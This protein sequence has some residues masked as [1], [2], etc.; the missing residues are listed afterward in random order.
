MGFFRGS[1]EEG[2]DFKVG[3]FRKNIKKFKGRPVS[4]FLDSDEGNISR[5]EYLYCDHRR[6]KRVYPKQLSGYEPIV[7]IDFDHGHVDPLSSVIVHVDI[8][9]SKFEKKALRQKNKE[10][11]K[12]RKERKKERKEWEELQDRLRKGC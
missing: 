6:G 1:V 11:G 9:V 4:E 5:T 8:P 2:E 7:D 3:Y 12:I 10:A